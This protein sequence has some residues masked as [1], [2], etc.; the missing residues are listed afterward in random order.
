MT[1][2]FAGK[3]KKRTKINNASKKRVKDPVALAALRL[4]IK[5]VIVSI[6]VTLIFT[7]VFGVFRLNDTGMLPN[8]APGDM[9][10][11]YRLDKQFLVGD[12]VVFSYKGDKRT[13]RVVALPGDTV[14]IDESGLK[15]NGNTQYEPKI[16]SDTMAFKDGTVFPV[17]LKNDEYFILGDNRDRTTDS[18]LFGPVTKKD[19][20][21]KV[22]TLIRRRNI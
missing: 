13:A 12:V 18:R 19:L 8:A 1:D 7:F 22:F 6:V 14:D 2:R 5:L 20:Y 16:Y 4:G 3:N 9:I 17:K 15:V 21:G 11:F 10:M